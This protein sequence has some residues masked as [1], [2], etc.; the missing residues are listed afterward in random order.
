MGYNFTVKINFGALIQT[1]KF[2]DGDSPKILVK[3][4]FKSLKWLLS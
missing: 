1:D 3:T 2:V 4:L